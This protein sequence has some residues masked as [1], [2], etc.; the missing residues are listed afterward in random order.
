MYPRLRKHFQFRNE[1][2]LFSE[3]HHSRIYSL[4]V[5]SN[6]Y[7]SYFE[8]INNLFVPATIDECYSG[9]NRFAGGIKDEKGEWN[10]KGGRDRILRIGSRELSI[11]AKLFND[12]EGDDIC[13]F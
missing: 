5:Y 3:V 2:K 10:I 6:A 1:L 4:N 9:A 13:I 7:N 11:F 8:S 12:D